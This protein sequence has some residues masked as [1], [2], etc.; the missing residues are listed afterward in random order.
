VHSELYKTNSNDTLYVPLTIHIT[1]NDDG[2]GRIN[3]IFVLN[4]LCQLN[5]DFE[6]T[7]LQFF[8]EGDWNYIDS[9]VWHNHQTILEGTDMMNAN[10]RANTV[11]SYFPNSAAGNAGYNL[12]H[13]DGVATRILSTGLNDHTWT[14]EIGHN[15]SVQHPFLGWEGGVSYDGSVSHSY[16]DPAPTTVTYDYTLFKDTLILDTLIIDTA[17]VEL[18]DGSNCDVASDGFCDTPPDYLS[19]RWPCNNDSMSQIP[20]RDP[21]GVQFQSDGRYFMSYSFDECQSKFS[22][23]QVDAMRAN[24]VHEKPG[25]LLVNQNPDRDLITQNVN[26][27]F[28]I[29]GEVV[30][31]ENVQL[32]WDP[33]PGATHYLLEL[34]RFPNFTYS[35][36]VEQVMLT[37]TFYNVSA[38][39]F[40]GI[41]YFWRVRPFN[42]SYACTSFNSGD[43][44]MTG[45]TTSVPVINEVQ[46]LEL[47]PN[48]AGQGND[49]LLSWVAS[50]AFDADV[51]IVDVTGR[52]IHRQP[53][54]FLK[55][56]HQQA[57]NTIGLSQGLYFVQINSPLG[58]LTKKLIIQ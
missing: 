39:L 27:T 14:H 8:M 24:L 47:I 35:F 11:N 6:P 25:H 17:F 2:S 42:Q 16:N 9:S 50:D 41:P 32:Q 53:M 58:Q 13:A 20:Q 56:Q 34:N 52:V 45:A 26:G 46:Y 44:F 23:E 5:R 37:D 43:N 55:G 18:M 57:I 40:V 21:N 51:R 15:L 49:V 36:L 33:V 19:F 29:N 10:N 38:D 22:Q 7:L 48:P 28:P 31:F 30:D 54:A 3:P 1:G 4:S 12:P